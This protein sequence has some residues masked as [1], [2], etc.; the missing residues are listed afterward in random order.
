[1]DNI[2]RGQSS[3]SSISVKHKVPRSSALTPSTQKHSRYLPCGPYDVN[4]TAARIS[5]RCPPREAY[6]EARDGPPRRV[7]RHRDK[8]VA[9]EPSTFVRQTVT[10]PVVLV[11]CLH[12]KAPDALEMVV[13]STTC[14]PS[15]WRQSPT[16][17]CSSSERIWPQRKPHR[18]S[19]MLCSTSVGRWKDDLSLSLFSWCATGRN[20]AS[21]H[22]VACLCSAVLII[23]SAC[24]DAHVSTESQCPP[25]HKCRATNS[26]HKLHACT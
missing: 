21:H 5:P 1:M 20:G 7:S 17:A 25:L 12:V 6:V 18:S 11:A 8:D 13:Q 19:H 23:V 15:L 2:S 3:S 24:A 10:A 22:A 14:A 9:V 26:R 16:K 4:P